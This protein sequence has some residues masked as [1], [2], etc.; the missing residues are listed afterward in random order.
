[1]TQD[2]NESTGD[3]LAA[4]D[5]VGLESFG[6]KRGTID[7]LPRDR[8]TGNYSVPFLPVSSSD[9]PNDDLFRTNGAQRRDEGEEAATRVIKLRRLSENTSPQKLAAYVSGYEYPEC[10]GSEL[11]ASAF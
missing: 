4:T 10:I 11:V 9:A 1:M 2:E 3:V 6:R 7:S 8:A 5:A